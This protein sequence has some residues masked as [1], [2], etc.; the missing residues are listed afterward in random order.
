MTSATRD[1]ARM[2]NAGRNGLKMHLLCC[3]S[4]IIIAMHNRQPVHFAVPSNASGSFSKRLLHSASAR[5]TTGCS[6]KIACFRPVEQEITERLLTLKKKNSALST[7]KP[8]T[9]RAHTILILACHVIVSMACSG[10]CA[11]ALR[12]KAHVQCSKDMSGG[13]SLVRAR[14]Q[15]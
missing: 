7:C 4:S 6:Y 2:A 11:R 1:W 8:G 10:Q 3:T 12:S 9:Y 14:E 5:R 15:T 13:L